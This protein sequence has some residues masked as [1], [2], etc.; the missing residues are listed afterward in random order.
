MGGV[1]G[2]ERNDTTVANMYNYI[3]VPTTTC[4]AAQAYR[5]V[6]R[7]TILIT[8]STNHMRCPQQFSSTKRHCQASIS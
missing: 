5:T 7:K 8:M 3:T 2:C 1:L 6:L 4:D